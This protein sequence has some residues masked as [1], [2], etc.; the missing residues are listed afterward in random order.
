M[1][2]ALKHKDPLKLIKNA[3]GLIDYVAFDARDRS[4]RLRIKR[5]VG[6]AHSPDYRYLLDISYDDK[7][8]LDFVLTYSF[9]QV[10]VKGKNLQDVILGIETNA[11][12]WIQE[13]DARVYSKPAPDAPIIESIEI[14]TPAIKDD[15]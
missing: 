7:T 15:D 11:C 3:D 12:L 10:Q 9:M 4:R 8:W 14:I 13:F 1:F 6:A 2:E 5:A